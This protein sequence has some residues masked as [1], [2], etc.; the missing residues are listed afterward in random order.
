M[1]IN[2]KTL[3]KVQL[4][5]SNITL[6]GSYTMIQLNSIQ[7]HKD[8]FFFKIDKSISVIYHI[9]KLKNKTCIRISIYAENPLTKFNTH[10]TLQ[11][12]Q[13]ERTYFNI[14]KFI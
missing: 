11:K 4:V 6:Q 5:K 9:K 8:F 13:I 7:G 10:L 3:N 2:V 12:V 1:K 14:I